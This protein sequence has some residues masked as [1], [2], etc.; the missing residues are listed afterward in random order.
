[1]IAWA[2]RAP[3]ERALLNPSFCSILLW[4]AASG[5]AA[6]GEGLL[7]FEETFL[8]LPL[9]L[10]RATRESLPRTIRTSLAVWLTDN[11]LA[12]GRVAVRARMLVPYTK[13][14][15]LFGGNHGLFEI[16]GGMLVP[17]RDWSKP[18][19]QSSSNTSDEV[20]DCAKRAEFVGAWFAKAGA[21]SS[22]LALF[23]VRP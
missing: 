22:V 13:E 19:S 4:S 21:A 18:I 2:E 9:V 20:R 17:N 11:P 3:E 23:G 8:V 10:H 7:A 6:A 5:H 15:V 16:R 14:A 1:M 12:R